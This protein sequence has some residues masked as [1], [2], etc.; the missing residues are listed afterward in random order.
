MDS[1]L[2]VLLIF[3]KYLVLIVLSGFMVDIDPPHYGGLS[4]SCWKMDKPKKNVMC[5]ALGF[6]GTGINPCC[7][8]NCFDP[9]KPAWSF[10]LC[11]F[12]DLILRWGWN[13]DVHSSVWCPSLFRYFITFRTLVCS[14]ESNEWVW[15]V[16]AFSALDPWFVGCINELQLTF[17]SMDMWKTL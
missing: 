2:F 3:Y 11:R 13:T 4:G 7:V 14:V 8:H 6:P 15:C 5:G 1:S 12:V 9:A 16:R 17:M 10:V